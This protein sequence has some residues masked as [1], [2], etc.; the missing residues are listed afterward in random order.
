MI[1][2]IPPGSQTF[3]DAPAQIIKMASSGL[4]GSDLRA[5]IKR[6]GSE[7]VEAAKD[8]KF[9]PGEV[10]VHLIAL[11]AT[12]YYGPNR[13]GDGFSEATCKK[14][15]QTFV[16][17]ARFYRNHVNKDPSKSYG[18]VKLSHYNR[19]MHRVEL[20]VAL[21]GDSRAARRNGGLVADKELEKLASGRDIGVSMA[22]FVPF[23]V[24]SVCG[25]R[26]RSRAE[27]C[28]GVDEGGNCPGGGLFTKIAT[29][30]EDGTQVFADNPDPKFF[31]ISHVPR[32]ADRIAWVLGQWKSA[33]VLG[34]VIGGAELAEK[35]GLDDASDSFE[36]P[37][38]A[39]RSIARKL[40]DTELRVE[41]EKRSEWNL[42]FVPEVQPPVNWSELTPWQADQLLGGLNREKIAMPLR[43]FLSVFAPSEYVSDGLYRQVRQ[44]MQG[45]YS[46]L[47]KS[48][49]FDSWCR[50]AEEWWRLARDPS[51][52]VREWIV[53]NARDYSLDESMARKRILKASLYYDTVPDIFISRNIKAAG[54]AEDVARLY[55]AYK[56]AMIRSVSDDFGNF[57]LTCSLAI[58]QNYM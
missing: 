43:G 47:I 4:S 35:I 5:F 53:K 48:A 23:D 3:D 28:R 44:Q 6:A 21:N 51:L 13:N 9:E 26:A 38:N 40:A 2:I 29:I 55:A 31:D 54:A 58:R 14:Y 57:D 15:H 45:V 34:R 50:L 22:C 52:V 7:F 18:I 33:S 39:W 10:P 37:L 46:R 24:C 12:E 56:A 42:A 11:G 30:L 1:K 8:I 19:D 32:P 25:N 16:K 20:L 17:Y 49:A 36:Y 41:H 27:Y